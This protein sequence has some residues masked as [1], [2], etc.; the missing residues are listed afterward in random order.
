M[1]KNQKSRTSTTSA[2]KGR[3]SIIMRTIK[4][5]QMKIARWKR[6]VREIESGER[7][8]SVSRWDTSGLERHIELLE[9]LY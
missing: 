3:G 2:G 7:K 4:R 1:G 5:S 8:G 9:S 6:Y